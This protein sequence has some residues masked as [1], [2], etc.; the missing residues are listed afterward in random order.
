MRSVVSFLTVTLTLPDEQACPLFQDIT[1]RVL[2]GLVKAAL[3][4]DMPAICIRHIADAI[5]IALYRPSALSG[6]LRPRV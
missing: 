1:L 4:E 3:S 6:P 2:Y 5:H